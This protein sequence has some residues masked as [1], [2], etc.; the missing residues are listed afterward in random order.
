GH[1]E[2]RTDKMLCGKNKDEICFCSDYCQ[3]RKHY[4]WPYKI[5]AVYEWNPQFLEYADQTIL[6]GD[7]LVKL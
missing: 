4:G 3:E 5:L 1:V 6:S 2:V 7:I